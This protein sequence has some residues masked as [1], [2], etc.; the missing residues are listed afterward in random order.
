MLLNFIQHVKRNVAVQRR[1]W[2][3]SVMAMMMAMP[4]VTVCI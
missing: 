2:V 1:L 3:E 4:V